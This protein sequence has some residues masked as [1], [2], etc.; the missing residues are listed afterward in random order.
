ML[1]EMQTALSQPLQNLSEK[2][3]RRLGEERTLFVIRT[4]SFP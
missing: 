2:R 3:S 1:G 4:E